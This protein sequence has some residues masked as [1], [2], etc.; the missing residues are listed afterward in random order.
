MQVN[1][2]RVQE[3]EAQLAHQDTASQADIAALQTSVAEGVSKASSLQQQMAAAEEASSRAVQV[4]SLA[5]L[6]DTILCGLWLATSYWLN[7]V[8]HAVLLTS[9]SLDDEC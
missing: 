4:P 8:H 5:F 6:H 7:R 1:G 9:W 2:Q 3:L